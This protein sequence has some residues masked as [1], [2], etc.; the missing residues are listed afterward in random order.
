[1]SE[2]IVER[3]QEVVAA[4]F[5]DGGSLEDIGDSKLEGKYD[6]LPTASTRSLS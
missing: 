5:L 4:S 3:R 2:V 6:S 1:L